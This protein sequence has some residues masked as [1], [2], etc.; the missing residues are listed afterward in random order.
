M[1][2]WPVRAVDCG[3]FR[4][5]VVLEDGDDRLIFGG[6]VDQR[7]SL[8]GSRSGVPNHGISSDPGR[9]GRGILLQRTAR[10]NV[11]HLQKAGR[12][13]AVEA[14]TVQRGLFAFFSGLATARDLPRSF[15]GLNY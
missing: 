14:R 10:I 2:G 8:R 15:N 13:A 7:S 4:T 9:V 6:A 11:T 3:W 1:H 12:K 5:L